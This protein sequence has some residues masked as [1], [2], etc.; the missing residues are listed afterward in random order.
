MDASSRGHGEKEAL[1]FRK[2]NREE[3]PGAKP[4]DF[5]NLGHGLW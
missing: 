2:K 4:K 3:T 5:L 1:L